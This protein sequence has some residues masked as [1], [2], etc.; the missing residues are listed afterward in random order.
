MGVSAV[1]AMAVRTQPGCKFIPI[2]GKHSTRTVG[3]VTARNHY[4]GRAQ[5]LLIK[6][7]QDACGRE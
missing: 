3:I 7:M 6:Q 4:Q 1:P 2:S 5:R